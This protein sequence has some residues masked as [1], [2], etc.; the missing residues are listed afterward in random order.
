M[1]RALEASDRERLRIVGELHDGVVQEL[2]GVAF[3]LAGAARASGL[4]AEASR[5]LHT[6][7]ASVRSGITSL[8]S[9]LLDIYPPKLAEHG[10][11]AALDDLRGDMSNERLALTVDV[12]ALPG[13]LPSAIEA[14]LYR[15]AREALR[16]VVRHGAASAAAVCCGT[17][18]SRVWVSVRDNGVGFDPE[19]LRQ[20][21]AEGHLGLRGLE[22]VIRDIGGSI[23]VESAPGRGTTVRV[24]VPVR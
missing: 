24:E 10:L 12:T 9:A 11:A 1:E 14:L 17:K 4:P 22:G 3:S 21:A 6:A 18:D 15:A 19:I 13:S 2:A 5:T 16:N 23:S 20:K 7:S 8:R